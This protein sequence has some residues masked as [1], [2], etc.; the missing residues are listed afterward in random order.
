MSDSKKDHILFD[1]QLNWL[2]DTRGILSARDAEG[3]I[4]VAMLP[5]Q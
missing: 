5:H 2:A 1:V 3:T 4:H